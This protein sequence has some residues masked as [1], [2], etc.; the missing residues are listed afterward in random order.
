MSARIVVNL[1]HGFAESAIDRTP[2][3]GVWLSLWRGREVVIVK[4]SMPSLQA[5]C[6]TLAKDLAL[7]TTPAAEDAV[8][9]DATGPRPPAA[10]PEPWSA[11]AGRA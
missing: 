4:L 5:L 7:S 10:E 9:P 6:V 8:A 11:P 3:G 2:D 1:G